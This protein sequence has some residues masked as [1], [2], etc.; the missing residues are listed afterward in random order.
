MIWKSLNVPYGTVATRRNRPVS[1]IVRFAPEVDDSE[2]PT[3]LLVKV[4]SKSSAKLLP[5]PCTASVLKLIALMTLI[6]LTLP[7]WL[8]AVSCPFA[9]PVG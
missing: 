7:P 3:R 8:P 1:P 4:E 6:T 2:L 5:V 9:Y